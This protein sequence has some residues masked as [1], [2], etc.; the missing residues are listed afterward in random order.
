MLATFRSAWLAQ[1]RIVRTCASPWHTHTH[2]RNA[3]NEVKWRLLCPNERLTFSHNFLCLLRFRYL[4]VSRYCCEHLCVVSSR[5]SYRDVIVQTHMIIVQ[6]ER[7]NSKR[8]AT[9]KLVQTWDLCAA[10]SK[11]TENTRRRRKG[12]ATKGDSETTS[13]RMTIM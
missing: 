5:N 1:H 10:I 8:A 2:I 7:W 12:M 13:S 4:F 3:H 9:R 11:G 6:R